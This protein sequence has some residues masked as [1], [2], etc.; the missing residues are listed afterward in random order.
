MTVSDLV[1]LRLAATAVCD[2]F[3]A[4]WLRKGED[5]CGSVSPRHRGQMKIR[6]RELGEALDDTPEKLKQAV[7]A[8]LTTTYNGAFSR[9]LDTYGRVRVRWRG[10]FRTRIHRLRDILET[11]K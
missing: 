3:E 9:G 8:F 4:S 2:A 5:E 1:D 6:L 11:T 7:E 10:A